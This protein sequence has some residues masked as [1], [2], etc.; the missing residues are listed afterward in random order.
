[1]ALRL[2]K[3]DASAL[4]ARNATGPSAKRTK[5]A[6]KNHEPILRFFE[7]HGLPRPAPEYQFSSLR[8][9]R[10]DF[11]WIPGRLALE[12][13]GGVW[14]GGRHTSGA[15]FMSDMEKYNAGVILGWRI[16]RCTPEQLSSGEICPLIRQ[17]LGIKERT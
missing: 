16:L 13:E 12:V 8:K 15:G 14:T 6:P 11:A 9:W 1:M 10:F 3:R 7:S 17:A 5:T 4:M 2:S